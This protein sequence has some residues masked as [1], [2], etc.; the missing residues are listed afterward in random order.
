MVVQNT[1]IAVRFDTATIALLAHLADQQ[2][3]LVSHL[4]QELALEGLEL[5]EDKYLS[6]LAEKLDTPDSKTSGHGDAW[7]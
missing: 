7:K 6:R 2:G 5:R 3:K 4:I 1:K